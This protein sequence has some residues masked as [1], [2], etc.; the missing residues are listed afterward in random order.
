MNEYVAALRKYVAET[1]PSYGSDAHSIME[2]LL[3]ITTNAT[4]LTPMP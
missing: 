2:L 3:S 1:P 4:T